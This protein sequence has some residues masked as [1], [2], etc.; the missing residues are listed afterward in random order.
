MAFVSV[1][2]EWKYLRNYDLI[3]LLDGKERLVEKTSRNSEI[4][5]RSVTEIISA[6]MPL[7]EFLRIA[8]ANTVE[9][10]LG[11]TTFSLTTEQ[12]EALRDLASRMQARKKN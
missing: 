12:L 8:N 11:T 5:S 3:F 1:S 4:E 10:K 7:S 2:Y 6:I 9:V